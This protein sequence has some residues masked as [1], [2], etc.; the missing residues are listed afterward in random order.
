MIQLIN[1]NN[2]YEMEFLNCKMELP[3]SSGL[4]VCSS[5]CGSG[6]TTM[7]QQIIEKFWKDGILVAVPTI[8]QA[9]EMENYLDDLKNKLIMNGKR[10]K[11]LILHTENPDSLDIYRNTPEDLKAFD[12]IVVTHVRLVIDPVQLFL[13]FRGGGYRRFCLLDEMINFFPTPFQIPDKIKP[14][15]TF[16]DLVKTHN[17]IPGTKIGTDETDR[18]IYQ[19]TY[20]DKSI[21]KAALKKNKIKMFS[22]NNELSRYKEDYILDHILHSGIDS[23]IMNKVKDFCSMLTVVLFDGTSDLIFPS[24]DPRM[25]SVVGYRYSSD[26]TFHSFQIELK[27]K[28]QISWNEEMVSKLLLSAKQ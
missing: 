4:H 2:K 15:I 25:I 21:M 28:T 24:N 3:L 12:V 13:N 10:L 27:R 20:R 11:F 17:G 16:A 5:G 6:K 18:T 14:V 19:H 23:P 8:E 22:A 7:I 1:N 9:K 26:I